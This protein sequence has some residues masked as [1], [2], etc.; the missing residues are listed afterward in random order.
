MN[1][2][3]QV[4]QAS[5]LLFAVLA[6]SV[7]VALKIQHLFQLD[8]DFQVNLTTLTGEAIK[9]DDETTKLIAEWK[10]RHNLEV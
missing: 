3:V 6:P 7:E 5:N 8:P 4:L 9:A 1:V 2:L 10:A